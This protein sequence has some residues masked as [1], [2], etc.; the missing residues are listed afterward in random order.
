MDLFAGRPF[1]RGDRIAAYIGEIFDEEKQ[2][3]K[4]TP[5]CL[6]LTR[7]VHPKKFGRIV[8]PNFSFPIQDTVPKIAQ[9]V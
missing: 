3:P 9:I 4:T 8:P 2:S 7:P 5:L 6:T 1:K